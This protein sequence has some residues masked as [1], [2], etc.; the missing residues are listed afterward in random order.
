MVGLLPQNRVI[1]GAGLL[2]QNRVIGGA[3]LLPQNRVIG[4]VF[5]NDVLLK[6]IKKCIYIFRNRLILS[7]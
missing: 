7:I 3:G 1:G 4:F 5:Q 2:P 6:K